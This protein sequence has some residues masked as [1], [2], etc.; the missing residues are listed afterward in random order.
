M[1]FFTNC[2]P[3]PH[4]DPCNNNKHAPGFQQERQSFLA[5]LPPKIKSVISNRRKSERK[6]AYNILCLFEF[7]YFFIRYVDAIVFF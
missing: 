7:R 3:T 2:I 6:I 1:V 4:P 5:E